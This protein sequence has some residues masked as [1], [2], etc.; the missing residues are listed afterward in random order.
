MEK[1]ETINAIHA[2]GYILANLEKGS[3]ER[4]EVEEKLLELI[5][6]L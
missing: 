4:K 3:K 1:Q 5:K 2:I 6:K